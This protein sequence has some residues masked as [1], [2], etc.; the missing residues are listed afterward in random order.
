MEGKIIRQ[1][2][3]VTGVDELKALCC[4]LVVCIHAKTSLTIGKY[5]VGLA[6]IA[7]PLFLMITGYF[8]HCSSLEKKRQQLIHISKLF[9]YGQAIYLAFELFLSCIIP[10][11][12]FWGY[13]TW[14]NLMLF[15]FVNEPHPDSAHLW[16][17][18]A[19]IYVLCISYY[20][21]N[22][23]SVNAKSVF[24]SVMIA[25]SIILGTYSKAIIG[26]ALPELLIRNF[27]FIGFPYFF[28]GEVFYEKRLKFEKLM[29]KSIAIKAVGISIVLC[30]LLEI[31]I[32]SRLWPEVDGTVYI[33][34]PLL[35]VFVFAAFIFKKGKSKILLKIGRD[36]S[37][38]VYIV[39]LM[40]YLF[41][42]MVFKR[43]GAYNISMIWAPV[44]CFLNSLLLAV[45]CDWIKNTHKAINDSRS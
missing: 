20:C 14:K 31:Y 32:V 8:Y 16:Y 22:Y 43:L 27:L 24:C 9:V 13:F 23:I 19:L 3:R 25:C 41:Q 45:V 4:F 6:R 40:V 38:V 18:L 44:I 34:T 15:L 12:D 29:Q 17:L 37:T 10:S 5:I 28:L 33:T 30:S 21:D 1:T 39:H 2:D 11:R 26:K 42:G 35:A 36:Y 7:V